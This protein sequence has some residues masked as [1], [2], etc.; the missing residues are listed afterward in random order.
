[1]GFPATR[2]AASKASTWIVYKLL[3]E[4][5]DVS[6]VPTAPIVGVITV[7]KVGGAEAL[8]GS[9]VTTV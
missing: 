4:V 6:V 5:L 9:E 7:V 3:V 1:M 2:E 8:K